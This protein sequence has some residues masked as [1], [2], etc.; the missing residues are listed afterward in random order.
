VKV[1]PY[2]LAG[3]AVK[4]YFA[5]SPEDGDTFL[6]WMSQNHRFLA[7]DTETTGLDIY[8]KD[9]GLRLVQVGTATEAW[10]LPFE[11]F[12]SVITSALTRHERFVV[13]NA[14][15][16]A[17]VLDRAGVISLE[18]LMPKVFDT[19]IL[20]HLLDPRGREEGGTGHG[21]KDLAALFV[22][23]DAPDTAKGLTEVFRKEYKATKAEGWK[24]V[25]L[26]HPTYVLY[27]GLDVLLTARLF[28]VLGPMV[29]DRGLAHLSTFEH[30]LLGVVTRMMRR[31]VLLDVNYATSLAQRLDLEAIAARRAA[32]EYGVE[33]VDSPRQVA[34]AL[35][36]MGWTPTE[37]TAGGAAK[38]DKA[39]LSALA[40]AGNPLAASIMEAKRAAKWRESYALAMLD[41]RDAGNR[42][43]PDISAL[44]ARTGRMSISR[45]PLQQLPSKDSTI[46]RALIADPGMVIGGVDYQAV[47]MRV[48][49][50]LAD[51]PKMKEAIH[52][53][54]DLHSYTANLVF[55]PDF[56]KAQRTLAK[57]VGFGK[58]YG[59]GADTIARQ[60]GA[61]VANV[62]TAIAAYDRTFPEIRRYAR[63][64]QDRATFGAREVITPSGRRLPLDRDRLYAATNYVVQSTARDLLAQALI[65]LEEAGLGEYLLLPVHDEVVFQAPKAEADDVARE[66]ARVMST[67]DFFGVPIATDADVYGPSWGH[68]YGATE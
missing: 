13:H 49:A 24:V 2:S 11:K 58:V 65:D 51:V 4:V 28:S 61:P 12:R 15:F 67:E 1:F 53:G 3:E 63:H 6:E 56:T 54:E 50:A 62:K 39:V 7:L 27:A 59:G 29:R 8:S 60:T 31:G 57:M 30:Q 9:F 47:E 14:A 66:I 5:T 45:P 18:A 33:S 42:I 48:L 46:R 43:H 17:Q 40:E 25:D 23:A 35:S 22:D 34:E 64:L 52:S 38:V 36:G 44:Q 68:G 41:G 19:R 55:G 20:A 10:V 26:D 16:D 32:L 21:L 37:F